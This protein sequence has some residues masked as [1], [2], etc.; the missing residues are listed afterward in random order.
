LHN[1]KDL[2]K[3]EIIKRYKHG[4]AKEQEFLF[5]NGYTWNIPETDIINGMLEREDA[6]Y[7]KRIQKLYK[8]LPIPAFH[9]KG[10]QEGEFNDFEYHFFSLKA[11][12]VRELEL[13]QG[14]PYGGIDKGIEKL[15]FL[16]RLDLTVSHKGGTIFQGDF[17][18]PSLEYLSFEYQA[19]NN[20]PDLLNRF[21]S[22]KELHIKG[23]HNALVKIDLNHSFLGS[24]NIERLYLYF[25]DL[26]RFDDTITTLGHLNSLKIYRSTLKAF[27]NKT[28][29]KLKS[30]ETLVL[31]NNQNFSLTYAIKNDLKKHIRN[32][33]Y[34]IPITNLK[35]QDLKNR[36][37]GKNVVRIDSQTME[38][39][40]FQIEEII[41]LYGTKLSAGILRQGYWKD[42]GLGIIR[43][44]ARIRENVGLNIGDFLTIFKVEVQ[45]AQYISLISLDYFIIRNPSLEK[46]IKQKLINH[47][48][49]MEDIIW[50]P[51][52]ISKPIRFKVI[53]M[54]PN[55]RGICVIRQSTNIVISLPKKNIKLYEEGYLFE[56]RSK[57]GLTKKEWG[58][59]SLI[60]NKLVFFIKKEQQVEIQLNL[61]K[62]VEQYKSLV[63]F[64]LK[65]GNIWSFL[66]SPLK[67]NLSLREVIECRRRAASLK[68]VI[69]YILK[70]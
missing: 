59:I 19:P 64:T 37:Y 4:D 43:I 62:N 47:P 12:H 34:S 69:S 18:L 5:S 53:D 66:C 21:P 8:F 40:G 33:S 32:F 50:I 20:F 31:E 38:K 16:K 26:E 15:Q 52:G 3:E 49:S 13:T 10:T 9:L 28:F 25:V 68:W 27:S 57:F 35:V 6:E 22:L 14:V 56:G 63:Y 46:F 24:K 23:K 41:A 39:G 30:L 7:M 11:G 48:I 17:S 55:Y 61:I 60:D 29:E 58:N 67:Y 2:S 70:D 44:D 1:K 45:P 65:D 42:E 36:D 54:D 51:F